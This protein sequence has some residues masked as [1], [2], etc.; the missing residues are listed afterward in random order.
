[1]ARV[2]H[3]WLGMMTQHNSNA[4]IIDGND[5]AQAIA[6]YAIELICGDIIDECEIDSAFD[7]IV[8][9]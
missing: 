6:A 5:A 1:M 9:A 8:S 2:S 3:S 7:N 4:Q